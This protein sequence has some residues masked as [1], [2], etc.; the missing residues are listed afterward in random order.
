MEASNIRIDATLLQANKNKIVRVMGKCESF[1]H[2]SS[3]AILVSNGTIKLDLSQ[4]TDSPLEINKNY[5]IIG[6]V[7]GNELK[8]YVYSVIELSDNLDINAASK[9]A[10]YAQ[11]VP[12]LYIYD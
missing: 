10:Q 6:K 2:G 5:E 1:D 4:V 7:N 9:L 11:K 12:E 3:Q 8:I